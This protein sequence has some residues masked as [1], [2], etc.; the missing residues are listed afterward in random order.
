M[1][2]EKLISYFTQQKNKPLVMIFAGL[3]GHGKTE[4]A[5]QMGI[6]LSA[7]HVLVDCTEMRRETDLFGPKA[8]YK[9]HETGSP[10]NN[11]LCETV[12][13]RNIVFLDEFEKTGDEVRQ[14]LL[15]IW[16][17]G[18]FLSLSLY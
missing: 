8:P 11:H 13:K 12:K 6:Y 9:G 7:D 16:Q 3:S 5:K 14:A 1:V 18:N 4:L 15:S 2:I 17:D 10:L